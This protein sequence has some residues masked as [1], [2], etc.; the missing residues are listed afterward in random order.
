MNEEEKSKIHLRLYSLKP[1]E[2]ALHA[3]LMFCRH[4]AGHSWSIH[5]HFQK[6]KGEGEDVN[7]PRTLRTLTSKRDFGRLFLTNIIVIMGSM[8]NSQGSN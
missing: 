7:A 4:W 8:V 5:T 2:P 6:Q 1:P 3:D